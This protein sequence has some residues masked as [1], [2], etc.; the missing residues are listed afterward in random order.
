M[1]PDSPC[2]SR[3]LL[4]LASVLLSL[5]SPASPAAEPT[6]GRLSFWVPPEQMARFDTVY[7]DSIAP[8]LDRHGF[9][10]SAVRGRPTEE[11]VFSRLFEFATPSA[12]QEQGQ[13]LQQD[14]AYQEILRGL[15]GSWTAALPADSAATAS[16]VA[17]GAGPWYGALSQERLHQF[18]EAHETLPHRLATSLSA[19]LGADVSVEP[20][21]A[22]IPIYGDVILSLTSP[23]CS[24]VVEMAPLG[25]AVL[26]NLT[27]PITDMAIHQGR[28]EADGP[29]FQPRILSPLERSAMQRVGDQLAL[30]LQATWSGMADVQLHNARVVDRPERIDLCHPSDLGVLIA[31]TVHLPPSNGS[32]LIE[33]FYPYAAL[34]PSFGGVRSSLHAYSTPAAPGAEVT[35]GPGSALPGEPGKR[36]WQAYGVSDGLPAP[37]VSALFQDREGY[38][39]FGTVEGVG[40]FNSIDFE[41]FTR[42]DGLAGDV[43][44]SICQ[45]DEGGVWI[46]TESGA[47]RFDGTAFTNFTTADG[48]PHNEIR[49]IYQDRDGSLW[50]GTPAGASRFDGQVFTNF[51]TTDGLPHDDVRAIYQD[52]EGSLWFG[53]AA[54]ASRFDGEAFT[55]F[56]TRDGLPDNRIWAIHEDRHG[57]LWFGTAGETARFDGERFSPVLPA[58]GSGM[59]V[60]A[61]HEDDEGYLWLAPQG[62][63]VVR[64]DGNTWTAFTQA[65]GLSSDHVLS[66]VQDEE[67]HLWFGTLGGG[68]SRYNGDTW[69]RFDGYAAVWKG[70]DTD[71]WL[72]G[73]RQGEVTRCDGGELTVLSADDGLPEGAVYSIF[74]DRRGDLWFSTRGG[75]TRYDGKTF[76]TLAERHGLPPGGA[77]SVCEDGDANLWVNLGH[78]LSRYDGKTW[79]TYTPED[80]IFPGGNGLYCD[81]HG[82]PWLLPNDL[83]RPLRWDGERLTPRDRSGRYPGATAYLNPR[84]ELA[85]KSFPTAAQDGAPTPLF[86]F[87]PDRKAFFWGYHP[88]IQDRNGHYWFQTADGVARYDGRTYQVLTSWDGLASE[89]ASRIYADQEGNIWF[90]N[91]SVQSAVVR[92]RQPKPVPPRIFVDAVVADKRYEGA[93]AVTLPSSVGTVSFE[94]HGMSMKTAPGSIVYRYRLKGLDEAWHNTR[95]TQ[96][97]YRDLPTGSYTFEV[98]AVD[99]DLVYSERPATAA[100]EIVYQPV[101]SS[102]RLTDLNIQDIFASFYKTYAE[103]PVG[104]VVVTNDDP[105]EVEA[106]LSFYI[107]DVM[108][109]PTERKILLE[110]QSSRTIA[111]NAILDEQVLST[112]GANPVQAEV[113]LS[114]RADEQ[115]LA[116]M[117][118]V[119]IIVHGRGALTWE[120]LG[121]AVAFVTP[122]DPSVS[123]F[124]RRL[125]DAYRP[126]L[127]ERRIDGNIPTAMLIYEALN[128]HG[129]Q[130]ARDASSPYSQV[131]HDRAAVDHIK[132]PAELLNGKLGDCDDLTVLYCALLENLDIPTALVDAPDHIFMMFDAGITEKRLYGFALDESSYVERGGTFWIPVEVTRLGEGSFM[133]AWSLGSRTCE[134]LAAAGQL[135]ITDVRKEMPIYPYAL[136]PPAAEIQPPDA[137]WIETAFLRGRSR[138]QALREEYIA[139]RYI[140]PL[141]ENPQDH[142]RRMELGHALI[143]ASDYNGAIAALMSLLDTDLRGEASYNIACAYAG[144]R[145]YQSAVDCVARALQADPE[146]LRY[147]RGLDLLKGEQRRQAR[148]GE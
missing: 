53:T 15:W 55:N 27:W 99:R 43:I 133:E 17:K 19:L 16:G 89:R 54:G 11:A 36:V 141:L 39:W 6:L 115:T 127:T 84:G 72:T 3:L 70:R 67:G 49:D 100:I 104:T 105:N 75:V 9:V 14:P 123:L 140:R 90:G 28:A 30:D 96:V 31:Y 146:N 137:D 35:A 136:P 44:S 122:E 4:G 120:P 76:T 34:I 25:D 68:V 18:H 63:G 95:S 143:Q 56:T 79:S 111:M 40:R 134:S 82:D 116:I 128:A 24:F 66:I 45:D 114:C 32:G 47:S 78:A 51:T 121:R 48:L 126:Y 130:Y 21:F 60:Q 59:N 97:R 107:P 113:S 148:Q 93:A 5:I 103:M 64:F 77:E 98:L 23:S 117:E 91:W 46:G 20:A 13:Q 125:Y 132:Y 42:A 29:A 26:I 131:R 74:R 110:P 145:D 142:G 119:G 86:S 139:R 102:I 138:L 87:D 135:A 7:H 147:R 52:S 108:R 85:F 80:G 144:Q 71:L 73:P 37:T 92:F 124:A 129:I 10:R 109:R 112:E 2:C 69:T 22:D 57:A 101:S 8:I 106:V 88:A 58:S 1:L 33:I 83:R 62:S 61:I 50:F 38:L 41:S 94:F 12:L 118:S 81:S 65:D